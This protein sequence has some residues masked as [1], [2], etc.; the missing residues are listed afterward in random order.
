MMNSVSQTQTPYAA[1]FDRQFPEDYKSKKAF[2]A[3]VLK[4][5]LPPALQIA[6]QRRE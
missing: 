4:K 1:H 6:I 3:R 2:L 5:S